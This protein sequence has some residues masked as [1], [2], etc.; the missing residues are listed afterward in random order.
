MPDVQSVNPPPARVELFKPYLVDPYF[1]R[2][3]A[4]AVDFKALAKIYRELF[5]RIVI[6]GEPI[7]IVTSDLEIKIKLLQ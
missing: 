6:K 4:P 5:D 7:A 1:L 3:A 2:A